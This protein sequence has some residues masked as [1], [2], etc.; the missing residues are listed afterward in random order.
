MLWL[1]PGVIDGEPVAVGGHVLHHSVEAGGP[2]DDTLTDSDA[3]VSAGHHLA[4]HFVDRKPVQ[5]CSPRAGV[6]GKPTLRS[7]E[8][9]QIAAA[10]A[11]GKE[12][13]EHLAVPERLCCLL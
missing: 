7:A 6:A 3:S 13:D 1:Q 2:A 4:D 11:R 10:D 9:G 8:A 5:L 12:P